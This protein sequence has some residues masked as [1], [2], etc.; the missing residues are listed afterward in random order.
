LK[1]TTASGDTLLTVYNNQNDQNFLLTV[2]GRPL[3]LTLDPY[4]W[5]LKDIGST[6]GGVTPVYTYALDQ[7]YPNPFNPGTTVRFHVGPAKRDG[8]LQDV[9]LTVFDL[10]GRE[11]AVIFN[12]KQ[13]APGDYE[14]VFQ[15]AKYNLTSGTFYYQLKAGD[16]TETKKMIF[17]K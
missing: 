7:N 16:Y 3:S 4:G 14:V 5:I 8:A 13:I 12:E 1:F 17:I 15:P 2:K 10:L 9:S 6:S 11:V